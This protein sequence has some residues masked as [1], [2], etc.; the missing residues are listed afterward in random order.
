MYFPPPPSKPAQKYLGI[1][2]QTAGPVDDRMIHNRLQDYCEARKA[3][4]ISV[5]SFSH[6]L[7]PPVLA[8]V[9]RAAVARALGTRACGIR[10]GQDSRVLALVAIA[11]SH[12]SL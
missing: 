11:F 3:M 9:A 4:F 5:R 2:L 6:Y 10:A 1:I 7:G 12:P 8:L